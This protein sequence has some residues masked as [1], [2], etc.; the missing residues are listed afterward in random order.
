[1]SDSRPL[2]R[3]RPNGTPLSAYELELL[4]I[5]MEEA[6]EV[7]VA[8]SK[9]IRFGREDRPPD[10]DVT[11]TRAFGLEIGD[12]EHMIALATAVG[13]ASENDIRVGIA[14]KR[15]RLARYMQTKKPVG[16]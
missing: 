2:A 1:M 6:A 11:N 14:R 16:L 13:L 12:L 15:E 8:A 5:L 10:G 9:I 7:S 4:V 3:Y